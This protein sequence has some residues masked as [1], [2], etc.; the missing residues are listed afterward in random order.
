MLVNVLERAL[1]ETILWADVTILKGGGGMRSQNFG[2][3]MAAQR[4]RCHAG[5]TLKLIWRESL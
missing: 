3:Q 4:V 2:R 5:E 1:A